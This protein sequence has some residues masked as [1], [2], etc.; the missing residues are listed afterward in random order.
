M[1]Q[2]QLMQAAKERGGNSSDAYWN[3]FGEA[4]QRGQVESW[5]DSAWS[6]AWKELRDSGATDADREL[7]LIAWESGFFDD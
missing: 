7:C 4:P 3:E 2:D 1:T 6:I 5:D